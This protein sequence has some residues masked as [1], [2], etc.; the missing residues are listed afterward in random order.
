MPTI[1]YPQLLESLTIPAE[2]QDGFFTADQAR[3]VDVNVDRLVKLASSGH[4]ERYHQGVYRLARWPGSKHPDLWPVM[5]WALRSDT[6]A[7]FSH[8]TALQLH[9][10]SNINPN[11]IDLTFEPG[12]R[13]RSTAPGRTV[14]HRRHLPESDVVI[15]DGLRVTSLYRTLLDLAVDRMARSDL[16]AVL[17]ST[18]LT[19]T[20][21]QVEQLQ[22]VIRL[23]PETKEFI[24]RASTATTR[25]PRG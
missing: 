14:L 2:R 22:S 13:V 3:E 10:V 18:L 4:I 6:Q 9:G 24:A 8:R 20:E 25:K 19:L 23:T 5:L 15:H 21:E 12:V 7:A 11:R 17:D 16:E 1:V